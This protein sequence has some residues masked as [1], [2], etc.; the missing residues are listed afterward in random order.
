MI[1]INKPHTTKKCL[2]RYR[3]ISLISNLVKVTSKTVSHRIETA[4]VSSGVVPSTTFAYL[5][6]R[7][8]SEIV[9]AVKDVIED[10]ATDA[11]GKR[12]V[13]IQSDFT[14]AFDAISRRYIY[15]KL[16]LYGFE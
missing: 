2:K 9:R 14:S 13:I 15:D 1:L 4:M 3:P 12:A 8:G 10:T 5:K 11:G 6:G 16:R 7:A